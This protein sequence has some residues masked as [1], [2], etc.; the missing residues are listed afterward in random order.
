MLLASRLF[1]SLS[2]WPH[3]RGAGNVSSRTPPLAVGL[4]LLEDLS[5]GLLAQYS[6]AF[7]LYRRFTSVVVMLYSQQ[8]VPFQLRL[9]WWYL[10]DSR[11]RKEFR[12]NRR[13]ISAIRTTQRSALAAL[14]RQTTDDRIISGPFRGMKYLP[15]CQGGLHCHKLLGTY[16][17][18]LWGIIHAACQRP[19]KLVVDLGAAEGYYVAGMALRLSTAHIVAFEAEEQ[20]HPVLAELVELNGLSHRVDIRGLCTSVEL[21]HAIGDGRQCLIICDIE[22]GEADLLDPWLAPALQQAD[23][24]VEV[25][26]HVRQNVCSLL[27]DR[28][29]STHAIT[30]ISVRPRVDADIPSQINDDRELLLAGL[31]E[32]R[33]ESTGWLWMQC[34]QPS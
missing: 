28:F 32:C 2:T 12:R 5:R 1:S 22:G 33:G 29:A 26:N 11:F 10:S 20:L 23:I 4:A 8:L 6:T 21:A 3:W 31:D 34:K 16:E 7:A 17:M 24:L 14:R 30:E 27:M 15:D 9:C 18:E 13:R 19:Y 25:H